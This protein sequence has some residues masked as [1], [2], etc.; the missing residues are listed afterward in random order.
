MATFGTS[1][2]GLLQLSSSTFKKLSSDTIKSSTFSSEQGYQITDSND[3]YKV[4]VLTSE[5]VFLSTSV[6]QVSC[7]ASVLAFVTA[8]GFLLVMGEDS[9][10][11]GI[12]GI[13]GVYSLKSPA[14]VP[15]NTRV[16]SVQIGAH[17]AAMLSSKGELYTWGTGPY[18]ELGTFSRE[19]HLPGLVQTS[20]I[21]LIRQVVCG[22]FFTAFCTAGGFVYIYGKLP[23]G[24]C[25][26]MKVRQPFTV[27][28]MCDHFIETLHCNQYFLVAV[29]DKKE[30]YVVDACMNLHKLPQE[31]SRLACSH[32][33]IIGVGNA[34][35]VI[36]EFMPVESSE[37][38]A[39]SLSESAYFIDEIL[40][41]DFEMFSGFYVSCAIYSSDEPIYEI[42]LQLLSLQKVY[43]D[44]SEE[45]PEG[46]DPRIRRTLMRLTGILNTQLKN[47]KKYSV[48]AV[49]LFAKCR[50]MALQ[51]PISLIL[52]PI[53]T[54]LMKKALIMKRTAWRKYESFVE[55]S[56]KHFELNSIRKGLVLQNCLNKIGRK[57]FTKTIDSF[58]MNEFIRNHKAHI[59][60]RVFLFLCRKKID[61]RRQGLYA[62]KCFT[63]SVE[64][65]EGKVQRVFELVEKSIKL[66]FVQYLLHN[67]IVKLKIY[68]TITQI[69]AYSSA[70]SS[71][72]RVL[73]SF[74]LW[75][76]NIVAMKISQ[77]SQKYARSMRTKK[78]AETLSQLLRKLYKSGL[79]SLKNFAH[80]QYNRFKVIFLSNS[81]NFAFQSSIKPIFYTLKHFDLHLKTFTTS[82]NS[83]LRPRFQ[84]LISCLKF[85]INRRKVIVFLKILTKASTK[86]ANFTHR[87]LFRAFS[88][89]AGYV[90]RAQSP[91][92]SLSNESYQH[93][94]QPKTSLP[95]R[96][97]LS[98][99]RHKLLTKE[100]TKST[101]SLMSG[102]RTNIQKSNSIT[103]AAK[104]LT[105][106]KFKQKKLISKAKKGSVLQKPKI[107]VET[108]GSASI[109]SSFFEVSPR[110]QTFLTED[111][112]E[113]RP[114]WEEQILYLA[115][116][117]LGSLLKSYMKGY[118]KVIVE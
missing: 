91:A 37:C 84:H 93:S 77:I 2:F 48:Y 95:S 104:N 106:C 87:S 70:Q 30:A 102:E 53:L 28:G 21:F 27:K 110:N 72:V 117:M 31:F 73:K 66:K 86:E 57:V 105:P 29:T 49:K 98:K 26:V 83:V 94:P 109:N 32:T 42:N 8:T 111:S 114:P 69:V 24:D 33:S 99:P 55:K 118:L 39:S 25:G 22:D 12:L 47:N 88:R 113:K 1:C 54:K 56:K 79:V 58:E 6:L 7:N 103:K 80:P 13:K 34:D 36:H 100:H 17:H 41:N 51:K 5:K 97:P 108:E 43:I 44:N 60:E 52:T 68:K 14:K 10:K 23:S 85:Y 59:A 46:P 75:K 76:R 38:R 20:R 71:R 82:L 78:M 96:L 92:L 45:T 9:D 101:M 15:I 19:K 61:I 107:Y 115:V 81:L 18:G 50:K 62:I 89:L 90:P 35:R 3:L 65:M 11:T 67:H 64:K 74:H 116:A 4:S 40:I 16:G 112:P 63:Q